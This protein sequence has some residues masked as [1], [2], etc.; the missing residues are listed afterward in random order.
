MRKAPPESREAVTPSSQGFDMAGSALTIGTR[1]SKLAMIQTE[2]VAGLLRSAHPDLSVSVR[3]FVT[4]GDRQQKAALPEI[5]GKGL[6]TA[7]L[8]SALLDGSIDLA[9]HSAKDLPTAVP[10]GLALAAV[11]VRQDP[12]DALISRGNLRLTELRVDALVGTSSLRR[13]AQ[14]RL[15][16]P[17]LKFTV[18]RGNV[19]T[20]LKKVLDDAQCDATVLAIAGLIRAGLA[21]RATE[22][23]DFDVMIPA[24]G[25][26]ALAIQSRSD[27]R[28]V[29]ALLAPLQHEP[30]FVEVMCERRIIQVLEGGCQA[31]I[32]ANAHAEDDRV[33]CRAVVLSPD[34]RQRAKATA[35]GPLDAWPD[36]ADKVISQLRAA[37]ADAIL[38]ACRPQS[39][40]DQAGSEF[41]S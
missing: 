38:K 17:D 1:G 39:P 15:H 4:R 41:R 29:R 24:A 6:F 26:G 9:V 18:L 35:E 20:R 32:G 33:T 30:T 19:D 8:E 22:V 2:W 7:E 16:R 28:R 31:P 25:Q 13:Q 10:D 27:D 23:L 40:S 36:V 21:D 3:K 37:R 34:G 5:G 12:R 11:P 14:L